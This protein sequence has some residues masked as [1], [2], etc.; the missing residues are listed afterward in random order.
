MFHLNPALFLLILTLILSF[1][2]QHIFLKY[3]GRRRTVADF[4]TATSF[5]HESDL[6]SRAKANRHLRDAFGILNPFVNGEKD[7]HDKYVKCVRRQLLHV[8]SDWSA[9]VD[10]AK[11]AAKEFDETNSVDRIRD[12]IRLIVMSIALKI[13]GVDGYSTDELL[14]VGQLINLIWLQAKSGGSTLILRNELHAVLQRWKHD[15][16]IDALIK[17]SNV[18]KECAILSILIPAYE[19]MYRVV[20]PLIF[21][22]HN[23]VSFERFLDPDVSIA[24]LNSTATFTSICEESYTYLALVQETLRRYPVVKRIKRATSWEI[25]AV[26]IAAIHLNATT[27]DAPEDFQPM[28]WMK[29]GKESGYMPFGAGRGRCIAN[30]GIVGLIVCIVLGVIEKPLRNFKTGDLNALLSNDREIQNEMLR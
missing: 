9:V 12:G 3:T 6:E 24:T 28:R 4:R 11:S 26:D 23:K 5:L 14:R 18:S 13:I 10:C 29:L 8:T 21:H 25:T 30:E 2:R 19:T 17:T 20:L 16:F 1:L 27:W 15:D 7:F 22:A